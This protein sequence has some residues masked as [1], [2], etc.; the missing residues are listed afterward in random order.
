SIALRNIYRCIGCTNHFRDDHLLDCCS[1]VFPMYVGCR[2]VYRTSFSS[3]A[4]AE[5]LQRPKPRVCETTSVPITVGQPQKIT[6][7]ILVDDAVNR[8]AVQNGRI[9]ST[10]FRW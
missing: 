3:P 7:C 2:A 9:R 4:T 1:Q 6:C 5:L 10:L 8:M